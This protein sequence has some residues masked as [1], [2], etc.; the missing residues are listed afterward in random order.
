MKNIKFLSLAFF[1]CWGLGGINAQ[2]LVFESFETSPTMHNSNAFLNGVFPAWINT[3]GTAS[4]TTV[5]P[6]Q[7]AQSTQMY[8]SHEPNC[9]E[10][11]RG[12]GIALNFDFKEGEC[13]TLS[14]ALRGEAAS[15]EWILL[16][17]GLPSF[18]GSGQGC[19]SGEVIPATPVLNYPV[20][21][22]FVQ[23]SSPNFWTEQEVT[24]IAPADFSQIWFRASNLKAMETTFTYVYLDAVKIESCC[25]SILNDCETNTDLT[26]CPAEDDW[27]FISIDCQMN[28][29]WQI[30]NGSSAVELT[31]N[32]Q[33]TI[34]HADP[35][36]YF[37]TLTD[38]SGCSEVFDF[39]VVEECCDS[40]TI[41]LCPAPQKPTCIGG[42]GYVEGL[43]WIPVAG[44]QSYII[45]II[46]E[47]D[48]C[49]CEGPQQGP[50]SIM[51]DEPP[52][53]FDQISIG[54]CYAWNVQAVCG[55]GV[56]SDPSDTICVIGG[57]CKVVDW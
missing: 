49:A 57:K 2:L 23:A 24:F 48:V 29:N 47:A 42:Q 6:F 9:Q 20:P 41:T 54:D 17:D 22:S 16:V 26:A 33:S 37:L 14:Y 36:T 21:G 25:S 39:T 10:P 27:G 5:F 28:Y 52:Y 34:L 53:L 44:A 40:T 8:V 35:G 7:G 45:T 56:L 1:L 19:A 18:G 31:G 12:E 13:Y 43:D 3:H 30:P 4:L 32:T 51:V 55:D 46:R 50:V 11:D 15:T 38:K